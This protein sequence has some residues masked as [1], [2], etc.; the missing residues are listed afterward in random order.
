MSLF[1]LTIP[2]G[3]V[4][5]F[6]K[7]ALV[8]EADDAATAK[9][10]AEAVHPGPWGAVTPVTV[11]T[12]AATLEGWV[13]RVRVGPDPTGGPGLPDAVDVSVTGGVG[14]DWDEIAADLV[15]ALN[16]TS[17]ISNA[18][19]LSPTLTVA[20]IADGIGDHSIRVEMTPPSGL[21]EV[22]QLVG[23]IVDGGIAA[24]DLTVAFEIQTT[25]PAIIGTVDRI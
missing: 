10:Y 24:A 12:A 23:T 15:I 25:N 16:A 2:A 7:R 14:D 19:Y 5:K 22:P 8:V 11:E 17:L 4:T 18:S 3:S 20:A 21:K 1:L 13:C 6:D 9:A